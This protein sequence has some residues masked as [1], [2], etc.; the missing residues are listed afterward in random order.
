MRLFGFTLTFTQII[1]MWMRPI[2]TMYSTCEAIR[3]KQI[4]C[5]EPGHNVLKI[6]KMLVPCADGNVFVLG[7]GCHQCLKIHKIFQLQAISSNTIRPV[8]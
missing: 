2:A 6:I 8:S 3:Q 5:L 4:K 7:Y 1:I